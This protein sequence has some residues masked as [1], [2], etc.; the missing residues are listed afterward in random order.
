MKKILLTILLTAAAVSNSFSQQAN[1]D[2]VVVVPETGV[3]PIKT[4]RNFTGPSSVLAASFFGSN[5]SGIT[6]TKYRLDTVVVASTTNSTTGLLL[7][8]KPGTYTLTLTDSAVTGRI[9]SVSI[10]WEADAGVVYK[11]NRRLYRFVNTPERLG[12]ERD[13]H[14][15]ADS[16]QSCELAEGQHL[17]APFA[18]GNVTKIA[19]LLETTVD[20]LSFIPLFG[21]WSRVPTQEEIEALGISDLTRRDNGSALRPQEA[22]NLMG[23]RTVPRARTLYIIGGK[24]Y[25][26]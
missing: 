19:E 8:A 13:E 3:L 11:K 23:Q 6:F 18:S 12:F 16:Y 24:K 26:R 22:Y 5:T 4:S 14:Y 15:A 7:F 10:S 1:Q 25:V 21:P 2:T 20:D 17:Y 9:Y